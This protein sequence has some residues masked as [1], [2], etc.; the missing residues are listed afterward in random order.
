MICL[1]CHSRRVVVID[2]RSKGTRRIMRRRK[3]LDCGKRWT[4]VE[5]PYGDVAYYLDGDGKEA[6]DG[7][8]HYTS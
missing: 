7:E 8:K 5:L 3:C 4:T 6:R 1:K 2:T